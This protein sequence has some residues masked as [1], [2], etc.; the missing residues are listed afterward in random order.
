[1]AG[2][3]LRGLEHGGLP[4]AEARI[5]GEDL[6]PVLVHVI[7]RYIREAYPA[8]DPAARPVHE[9]LLQLTKAWPGIVAVTREGEGDPISVWFAREHAFSDFHGRGEEMLDVVID[10]LDS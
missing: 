10:K 5:L 3:L 8:S 1:M 9:R 7:V 4:A 6:D 2:R